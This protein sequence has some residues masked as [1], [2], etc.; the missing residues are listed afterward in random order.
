MTRP[1]TRSQGTCDLIHCSGHLIIVGAYSLADVGWKQR[2]AD[3]EKL[4]ENAAAMSVREQV[5]A[6][7]GVYD[8]DG[9]G[10]ISIG[11]PVVATLYAVD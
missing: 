10:S 6:A 11:T 3:M 1:R 9:S 5:H 2:K 8:A 4:V 7:F